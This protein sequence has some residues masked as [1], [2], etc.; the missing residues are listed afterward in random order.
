VT[1]GTPVSMS[2][3]FVRVYCSLTIL[4]THPVMPSCA[5][6]LTPFFFPRY[7]GHRDLPS[8]P[9]RRSSDLPGSAMS[10]PSPSTTTPRASWPGVE[11]GRATSELQSRFELVCRLLL[12]KKNAYKKRRQKKYH[13]NVIMKW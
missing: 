13:E 4:L 1:V 3:F 2:P 11:I 7:R 6:R 10:W 9:T 8:F 5:A 12:E